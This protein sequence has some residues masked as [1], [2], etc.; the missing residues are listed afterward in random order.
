MPDFQQWVGNAPGKI[1]ERAHDRMGLWGNSQ[2]DLRRW[3][4]GDKLKSMID[5]KRT[6]HEDGTI[7]Y[8]RNVLNRVWDDKMNLLPIPQSERMKNPN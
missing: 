5:M 2:E 4:D 1:S 6:K 8:K 7:T 3:K